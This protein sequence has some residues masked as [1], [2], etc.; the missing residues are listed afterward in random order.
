MIAVAKCED[1][2]GRFSDQAY[3]D[4][5]TASRDVE[6]I[7]FEHLLLRYISRVCKIIYN[8]EVSFLIT[9]DVFVVFKILTQS[10]ATAENYTRDDII[11]FTR[12]NLWN[13]LLKL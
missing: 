6:S 4:S 7:H 5:G 8:H 9:I 11:F 2:Y 13:Y 12:N 1:T 10:S 3:A